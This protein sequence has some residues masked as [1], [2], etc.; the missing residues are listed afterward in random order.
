MKRLKSLTL[1]AL[2]A[3][4]GIALSS[5]VATGQVQQPPQPSSV[6][7]DLLQRAENSLNDLQYAQALGFARQIIDL[8][9]RVSVDKRERA[10]LVIAAA[11]YPEGEPSAQ[12]RSVALATFKQMVRSRLDLAIPPALRWAGLDSVLAEAKSTTFGLAA[13]ATPEQQVVGPSG[14][15]EIKVR[16][17]RPATFQLAIRSLTGS[18]AMAV[19]DSSG[20]TE[21]TLTFPAM[22]NERPWFATGDYEMLVTATDR[23]SGDTVTSRFTARVTAPPLTFAPMPSAIDSARFVPERTKKYG[24]KGI[25]VGGLVAGGIYGFSSTMHADTSFRTSVGPD[26]KGAG[27]AALA[28]LTLIAASYMD[29]GRQ[30]PSAIGANQKMRDDLATAI[31]NAQ[32]ENASRIAN[33]RTTITITS[34]AR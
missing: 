18:A 22:Q 24:W 13:T 19:T 4:F 12:R 11:N 9:D 26:S 29:K 17:S 25:I 5:G 30:I 32:A 15:G 1:R 7:D 20:G 31:R 3:A 2:A 23:L 28:G 27:I 6:I 14:R 10:M 16:T 8:G 34:G 21:A 33:H